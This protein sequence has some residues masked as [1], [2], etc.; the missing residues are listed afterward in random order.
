MPER[1]YLWLAPIDQVGNDT[2][3]TNNEGICDFK[4]VP[5]GRLDC[6]IFKT[7]YR[8]QRGQ[9]N[10]SSEIKNNFFIIDLTSNSDDNL[11]ITG[12][13]EGCDVLL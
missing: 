7:G 13:V 12:K 6:N 8:F 2:K 1:I 11:L 3:S 10:I 9:Q 5:V 4:N